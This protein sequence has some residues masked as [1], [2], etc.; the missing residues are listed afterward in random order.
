MTG[1]ST[2]QANLVFEALRDYE[3]SSIRTICDVGGG[4]GNL[5][6]ALI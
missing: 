4:Q 3:I 2:T 5:M 1:H 6:C